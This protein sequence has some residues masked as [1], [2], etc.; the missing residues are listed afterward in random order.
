MFLNYEIR[1]Y[2]NLIKSTC[3][4]QRDFDTK[5]PAVCSLASTLPRFNAACCLFAKAMGCTL[6]AI[7][8][9]LPCLLPLLAAVCCCWWPP[10]SHLLPRPV[11]WPWSSSQAPCCAAMDWFCSLRAFCRVRRPPEFCHWSSELRTSTPSPTP[12]CAVRSPL[13]RHD[14]MLLARCLMK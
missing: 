14:R 12:S 3:C 1:R 6:H 10:P 7:S 9:C 8:C 13:R 11:P 2:R 5:Q 4:T